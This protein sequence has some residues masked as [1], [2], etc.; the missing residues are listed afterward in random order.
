MKIKIIGAN[1]SNRMKLLKNVT[2]VVDVLDGNFEIE[3]LEE[4]KDLYQYQITN[5][6]GLVIKEK[7][8]SQGKITS[9]R[10]IKN[11]IRILA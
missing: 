8:V 3:L 10:D 5:A 6:P 2:R 1:S 9:E 7:L 4:E 11:F